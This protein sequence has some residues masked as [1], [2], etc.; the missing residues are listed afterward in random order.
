MSR[1]FR[2]LGVVHAAFFL[3]RPLL[4]TVN[5]PLS[6]KSGHV[7]PCPLRSDHLHGL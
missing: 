3:V 7:Q 6:D 4:I 1:R 5:T 2:R